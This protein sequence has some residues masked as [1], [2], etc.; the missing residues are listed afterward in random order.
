[1]DNKKYKLVVVLM[2]RGFAEEALAAAREAGAQGGTIINGRGTAK[3]APTLFGMAID[4]EK[5]ILFMAVE[6][7]NTKTVMEGVFKKVGLG[8]P[9]NGI[10]IA[11][12]IENIV[13]LEELAEAEQGN[14]EAK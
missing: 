13:G 12:P 2:N 3:S 6:K 4:P 11:L 5:S 9:A 1:M 7:S 14:I 10:C 8:T